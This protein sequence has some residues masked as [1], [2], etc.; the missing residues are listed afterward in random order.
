MPLKQALI[1][2]KN[3]LNWKNKHTLVSHYTRDSYSKFIT[4]I[5]F[6]DKACIYFRSWTS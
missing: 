1:Y 2:F 6:Y 5:L 4:K 3:F